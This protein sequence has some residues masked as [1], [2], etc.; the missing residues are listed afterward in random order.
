MYVYISLPSFSS[1]VKRIWNSGLGF[2]HYLYLTFYV[3]QRDCHLRRG[4][5]TRDGQEKNVPR[6][7]LRPNQLT[8]VNQMRYHLCVQASF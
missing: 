2:A 8:I 4:R 3:K 6:T 1:N 5:V 7:L